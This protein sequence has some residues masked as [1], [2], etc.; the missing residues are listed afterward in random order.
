[1]GRVW[2]WVVRMHYFQ[3]PLHVFGLGVSLSNAREIGEWT[4]V[5]TLGV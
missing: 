5:E 3:L 4:I 2:G 1:V